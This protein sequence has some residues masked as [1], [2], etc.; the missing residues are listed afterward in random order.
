MYNKFSYVILIALA[1]LFISHAYAAE[2][3]TSSFLHIDVDARGTAMGGAHGALTGDLYSIY[4]NPAG[5]ANVSLNELGFTYQRAFLDMN[6]GFIGY[7]LPIRNFGTIA[8]QFFFLSSGSIPTTSIDAVITGSDSVLDV[9]LGLSQSANI[10]NLLSY[11][12]SV[13]LIAHKL[14]DEQALAVAFDAGII[15]RD[16]IENL[17][18]GLA[19]QNVSTSYSFMSQELIE[20]RIIK[21]ASLYS[22]SRNQLLLAGDFNICLGGRD[23][24]N[25]G[26]EY[27]V[28]DLIALRAGLELMPPAGFMSSFS[29]GFGLNWRD[30]YSL[31][32][33]FSPHAELGANH[34]FSVIVKF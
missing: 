13:K 18:F 21:I 14:M 22:L 32:Y 26:A 1:F 7:A 29:T 27:W 28:L 23:T 20:P 5:L 30:T 8:G 31:D 15:H 19:I 3:V 16:I 25:F 24:A 2:T 11:G 33:S 17:D 34:R 6:Y 4:W 9:G 12:L 10:T